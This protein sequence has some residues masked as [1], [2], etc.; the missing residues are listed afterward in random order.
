MEFAVSVTGVAPLPP[1][2]YPDEGRGFVSRHLRFDS[3]SGKASLSRFIIFSTFMQNAYHPEG[4][5]TARTSFQQFQSPEN[6]VPA[7]LK[8]HRPLDVGR[9]GAAE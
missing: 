1:V 9:R 3:R 8:S 5:A 7:I 6:G 4:L 2:N